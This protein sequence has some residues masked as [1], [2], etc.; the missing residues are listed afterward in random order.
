MATIPEIPPE[1]KIVPIEGGRR[2]QIPTYEASGASAENTFTTPYIAGEKTSALV[3]NIADQ[4]NKA[5]DKTALEEGAKM[6]YLEQQRNIEA[7]NKEYI[8]GGT[9]F[10][11]SAQAYQKGAN[12]AYQM[13]KKTDYEVALKE[14]AEKRANDLDRYNREANEVKKRILSDV[15]ELLM[16]DISV[17]FDKQKLNYEVQIAGTQRKQQFEQGIDDIKNGMYSEVSKISNMLSAGGMQAAGLT[18]SFVNLRTGLESLREHYNLSPKEMREIS[19]Q[20]REKIFYAAWLPLEFER[21]KLDPEARRDIKKRLSKGNYNMGELGDE[22]G[23][24]IPGG[25]NI[26]LREADTYVKLFDHYEKEFA[27]GLAGQLHVF[28]LSEKA[29]DQDALKGRN[30]IRGEDGKLLPIQSNLTFDS[31]AAKSLGMDDKKILEMKFEREANIFAGNRVNQYLMNDITSYGSSIAQLD[32]EEI[33][34]RNETDPYRR[35]LI[36]AGVAKARKEIESSHKERLEHE[37]NGTYADYWTER[38][39][40]LYFSQGIDL[41]NSEGTRKWQEQFEKNGSNKPFFYSGLPSPQG[42]IELLN[43]TKAQTVDELLSSVDNLNNRQKEYA[44]M[45]LGSG[46][47]SLKGTEKDGIHAYVMLQN[48]VYS[49]QRPEADQLAAAILQRKQNYDALKAKGTVLKDSDTFTIE[50]KDVKQKFFDEFGKQIDFS[51]SYGKS[52]YDSYEAIYLK[53]RQGRSS[54][55]DAKETALKFVKDTNAELKLKNGNRVFMPKSEIFN[56]GYSSTSELETILNDTLSY[57]HEY[58]IIPALGQT[59]DDLKKDM[60]N[61]NFVYNSGGHFIL[62]NKKNDVAADVY[63]KQP[64]GKNVLLFSDAVVGVDRDRKQTTAFKDSESTWQTNTDF[65]KLLGEVKPSTPAGKKQLEP[66]SKIRFEQELKDREERSLS[67][68]AKKLQVTYVDNFTKYDEKLKK[69]V[70]T[71]E[72]WIVPATIGMSETKKQVANAISLKA[73]ENSLDD[74]DLLWLAQNSGTFSGF[75]VPEIRQEFLKEWSQNH[76]RWSKMTT[77]NFGATVMSP[78]QV[79]ATIVNKKQVTTEMAPSG[80]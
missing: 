54:E 8:G 69:N 47:K 22:F 40:P 45:W 65:T 74:R 70:Y 71:Y 23:D 16:G 27:Q 21:T 5:A 64:S 19:N 2:V 36:I 49:N 12:V 50:M 24:F 31:V 79:M 9:A 4:F 38:M 66:W 76:S 3:G 15:P 18:D 10:S 60:D 68:Y 48:L 25:K 26:S 53:V 56:Q 57:P 34:A 39:G 63:M 29:K 13:R 41:S 72:D 80:P 20:I 17:D 52:L 55:S 75:S 37:K 77:K 14:L 11:I 7:G 33:A 43:L 59:Y 46:A 44:S 78:L 1:Q 67:G 28:E 30:F 61:Y 35:S 32:Q 51:T 73:K 58:N 62:K 42:K 6:G